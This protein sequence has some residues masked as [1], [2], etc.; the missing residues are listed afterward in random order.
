M[1]PLLRDMF[2]LIGLLQNKVSKHCTPIANS[3]SE[4]VMQCMHIK[5]VSRKTI[6]ACVLKLWPRDHAKLWLLAYLS[7][8][9]DCTT[10]YFSH[11]FIT[12]NSIKFVYIFFYGKLFFANIQGDCN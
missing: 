7:L 4:S 12:V 3:L 9:H 10:N 8:M 1:S 6:Q 11:S 2:S 5:A